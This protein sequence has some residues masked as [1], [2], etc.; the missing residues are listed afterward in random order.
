MR[1]IRYVI[2]VLAVLAFVAAPVAVADSAG[3]PANVDVPVRSAESVA[4]E[5]VAVGQRSDLL[6]GGWSQSSDRAVTTSGDATGFHVLVADARDGYQW[7]TAASLSEPGFDADAW[8][9]NMCVTAS[10]RRAVVVYKLGSH[11]RRGRLVVNIGLS[12]V[13]LGVAV[14]APVASA[15][16]AAIARQ[17]PVITSTGLVLTPP[18]PPRINGIE[19]QGAWLGPYA[20]Q[21]LNSGKCLDI[22][23]AGT[24]DH[25]I[26]N[27]YRC[28]KGGVSQMWWTW[29]YDGDGTVSYEYWLNAHSGKCL[30]V[31]STSVNTALTQYECNWL[32]KQGW[33]STNEDPFYRIYWNAWLHTCME[34]QG[35]R[36]EDF[37]PIVHWHQHGQAHQRWRFYQA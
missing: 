23:G 21:N 4:P 15:Q 32:E 14:P 22:Y 18:P 20:V 28:V 25:N 30:Q 36:M 34:V 10:G 8:I 11:V 12:L 1:S 17:A 37:I 33:V 7:R 9:G 35:A 16:P 26:A 6:G 3:P 19:M 31:S 5:S 13:V 27:Q 24:Q 29:Q 2:S